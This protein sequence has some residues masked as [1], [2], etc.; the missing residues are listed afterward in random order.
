M[1]PSGPQPGHSRCVS[2][3]YLIG[4]VRDP[5]ERDTTLERIGGDRHGHPYVSGCDQSSTGTLRSL[6]PSPLSSLLDLNDPANPRDLARVFARGL[7][8][9]LARTNIL[10]ED[11]F[12]NTHL[13]LLMTRALVLSRTLDR[14][15][16]LSTSFYSWKWGRWI[17]QRKKVIWTDKKLRILIY[18]ALNL[19]VDLLVVEQRKEGQLPAWEGILLVKENK[20]NTL[21]E[22]PQEAS[23]DEQK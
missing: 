15:L 17:F 5:R 12:I 9:S 2:G 16:P 8:Y 13:I 20:R 11:Y 10:E 23:L 1:S 4:A 6:P 22:P 19:Y 21:A 14:V 7:T 18:S 3:G